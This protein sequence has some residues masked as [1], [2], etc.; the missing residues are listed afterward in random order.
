MEELGT[1]IQPKLKIRIP[2]TRARNFSS[3]TLVSLL[4]TRWRYP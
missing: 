4:S 3:F 1:F 2:S